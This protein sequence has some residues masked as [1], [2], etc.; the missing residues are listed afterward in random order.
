MLA[1]ELCYEFSSV[2]IKLYQLVSNKCP[3]YSTLLTTSLIISSFFKFIPVTDF[4]LYSLLG[5][6]PGTLDSFD[7]HLC[8][9]P[10]NELT[11]ALVILMNYCIF[12]YF[13]REV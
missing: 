12:V 6:Y 10:S 4:K 9:F 5:Y 3:T 8:V 7:F 13:F 1:S 2:P 11:L